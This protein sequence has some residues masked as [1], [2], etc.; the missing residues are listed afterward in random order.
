MPAATTTGVQNLYPANFVP[1]KPKSTLPRV[2]APTRPRTTYTRYPWKRAI[3]TTVFWIGE[4]PTQNNPTPNTM[5]S[6]D[7]RWVSSYGGYDDPKSSGRSGYRPSKFEPRQNPFYIALPYNDIAGGGVGTK[8]SARAMIPWF[9]KKFYRNGRTVLKGRWLAIRRGDKVCYAQWEDVGPFETD[10]WQYVFGDARPKNQTKNGAAGLDVSPAVR[11]FLGFSTRAVCD[12]R[13]VDEE[14]VPEG[15]WRNW[16]TNNPFAKSKY[17]EKANS[18]E[19]DRIVKLKE[20]RDA[21][22]K[23]MPM[24]R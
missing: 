7:Q 6:W 5:S 10:D 3:T 19:Y 22:I 23:Q 24:K 14:E 18:A 9:K 12:W 13:F 17:N 11:D 8:A 15:P 16:G 20:M 4:L 21:Y 2:F 1:P